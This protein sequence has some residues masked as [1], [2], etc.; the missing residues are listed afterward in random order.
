MILGGV[1]SV[2][3]SKLLEIVKELGLKALGYASGIVD[4]AHL[5]AVRNYPKRF[6]YR[7]VAATSG[8]VVLGDEVE[9]KQLKWVDN[10]TLFNNDTSSVMAASGMGAGD[11]WKRGSEYLI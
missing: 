9:V 1:W 10:K 4:F 8:T 2:F 7:F 6:V 5:T 11:C 3:C